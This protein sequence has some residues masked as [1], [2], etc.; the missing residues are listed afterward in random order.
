M[1]CDATTN[2]RA[3]ATGSASL[4]D[5]GGNQTNPLAGARG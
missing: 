4:G 3:I 2:I 1:L 5:P